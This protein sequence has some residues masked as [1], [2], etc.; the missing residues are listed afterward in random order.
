MFF[1]PPAH[2]KLTAAT[3]QPCLIVNFIHMISGA[4]IVFTLSLAAAFGTVAYV[5]Y[6]QQLEKMRLEEGVKRDLERQRQKKLKSLAQQTSQPQV[7]Q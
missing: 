1:S 6:S 3:R 4:H 2:P 7:S 5:H